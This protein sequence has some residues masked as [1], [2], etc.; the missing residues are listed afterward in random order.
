MATCP[1]EEQ[2]SKN[3]SF[4]ATN[5]FIERTD[6]RTPSLSELEISSDHK[7]EVMSPSPVEDEP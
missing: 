5:G 1:I 4:W 3:R 7:E 6:R 2:T